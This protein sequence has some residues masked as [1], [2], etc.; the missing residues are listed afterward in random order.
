M[1]DFLRKSD[2]QEGLFQKHT[3]HACVVVHDLDAAPG[4]MWNQ[5]KEILDNH[6]RPFVIVATVTHLTALPEWLSSHFFKVKE[7]R[8]SRESK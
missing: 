6:V 4:W 7:G 2:L 8:K 5:L 3:Q 1:L